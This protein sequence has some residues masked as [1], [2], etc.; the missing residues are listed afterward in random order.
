MCR[1]PLSDSLALTARAGYHNTRAKGEFA[2]SAAPLLTG[3]TSTRHTGPKLGIG[4]NYAFSRDL[5]LRSD[6]EHYRVKGANGNG[7][8][9]RMLSVGLVIPFGRAPV[10]SS[11]PRPMST[12]VAYAPAVVQPPAPPPPAVMAVAAPPPPP[13]APRRVSFA[14]ES[15]FDFDSADL[16]PEGGTALDNF[17]RDLAGTRYDTIRVEGHSDRL[18][19][20]AYNQTLSQQRADAVKAYLVGMAGLDPTKV[21]A[22]GMGESQASAQTADCGP[23]LKRAQLITCLQPDRRVDIEVSGTR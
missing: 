16:R 3:P 13:P 23:R 10:V 19:S 22:V 8:A 12:P 7:M 1:M 2:S 11:A 18:G 9:V 21:S 14:A 20:S 17:S 4:L 6:F 5:E 15:L